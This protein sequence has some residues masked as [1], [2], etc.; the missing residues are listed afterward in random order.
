MA[1]AFIQVSQDCIATTT[2]MSEE[3]QSMIIRV[4]RE[5]NEARD[6]AEKLRN[7]KEFVNHKILD[8]LGDLYLSGFKMVGKITSSQGGHNITNQ[9][10]RKLLSK[11]ENF[12]T[13][14]ILFDSVF[15]DFII[16]FHHI[17]FINIQNKLYHFFYI[18][19]P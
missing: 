19:M 7:E 9:G 14:V 18:Q 1:P 12:S 8:C 2:G 13:F 6:E 15:F 11:N 4:I 5:R 17:M 16:F 3:L 10:L